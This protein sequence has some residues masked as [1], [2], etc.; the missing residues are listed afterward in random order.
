MP[1]K[2]KNKRSVRPSKVYQEASPAVRA[3][4]APLFAPSIAVENAMDVMARDAQF[5]LNPN[6]PERQALAASVYQMQNQNRAP[7][8]TGWHDGSV[9]PYMNEQSYDDAFADEIFRRQWMM[10][11]GEDPYAPGSVDRVMRNPIL[12]QPGGR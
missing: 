12:L 6:H 3:V 9:A 1:D 11:F 7:Q 2:K 4:G 10:R 8:I 5:V